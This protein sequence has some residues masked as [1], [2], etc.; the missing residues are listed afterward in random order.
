[1]CSAEYKENATGYLL[2]RNQEKGFTALVLPY[3]IYFFGSYIFCRKVEIRVFPYAL[4][5]SIVHVYTED[6]LS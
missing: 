2:P 1:M 5:L 6:K 3:E 4:F